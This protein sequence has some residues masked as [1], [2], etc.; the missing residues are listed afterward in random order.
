MRFAFFRPNNVGE[1]ILTGI[2]SRLV[3]E[4]NVKI[5]VCVCPNYLRF[6]LPPAV[7]ALLLLENPRFSTLEDSLLSKT[8]NSRF[9][10]PSHAGGKEK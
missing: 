9:P 2:A 7:V 4:K 5:A 8:G 1:G 10:T 3:W 6:T